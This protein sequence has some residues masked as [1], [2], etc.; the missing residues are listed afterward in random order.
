MGEGAGGDGWTGYRRSIRIVPVPGC[1]DVEMEDD[2]HHFGVTV[3]HDGLTVAAVET[4]EPRHPW[5]MCLLAG[6]YLRERMAGVALADAARVENQRQ[7]CTHL[8]DLFVLGAAHSHDPA[9]TRY[10]IRVADV[11][12][13]VQLAELDRNGATVLRWRVGDGSA[14]DGIAGGN[15]AALEAWSRT[16]P[17]HLHEAARMLRRAV[18]V[19]RARGF[20]MPENAGMLPHMS[21]ACFSFQPERAALAL[22]MPDTIRDF[23]HDPDAMLS[24]ERET[25]PPAGT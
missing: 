21:G 1:V 4:R 6:A 17:D 20:T 25:A 7:H 12:A 19:G 23:S 14:P 10:D 9:P 24:P 5:T 11:V 2:F 16:L 15:F 22:R 13:G 3:F 8:Y 18:K